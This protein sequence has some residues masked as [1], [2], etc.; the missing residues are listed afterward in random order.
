HDRGA[1]AERENHDVPYDPAG[2]GRQVDTVARLH[3]ELQ[4]VRLHVLEQGAGGR[5]EDAFGPAGG[6]RREQDVAGMIEGEA[7]VFDLA[8]RKRRREVIEG[9]A[10]TDAAHVEPIRE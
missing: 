6:A 5:V 10:I 4:R 8:C 3:V 2:R 1:T 7:L 9:F